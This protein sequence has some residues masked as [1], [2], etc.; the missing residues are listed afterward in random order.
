MLGGNFGIVNKIK[1]T[2]SFLLEE[3]A[4]E[5]F[6]PLIKLFL[7]LTKKDS[8]DNWEKKDSKD[9]WGET[10][11]EEVKQ[12]VDFIKNINDSVESNFDDE[13]VIKQFLLLT[14]GSIEEEPHLSSNQAPYWNSS[15]INS[16][17]EQ[18][19]GLLNV[20]CSFT[21]IL[22]DPILLNFLESELSFKE[23]KYDS[24]VLLES[25]ALVTNDL[26]GFHFSRWCCNK[27]IKEKIWEGNSK[28]RDILYGRGEARTSEDNWNKLVETFFQ[29]TNVDIKEFLKNLF[30]EENLPLLRKIGE[31]YDISE[32]E[33]LQGDEVKE[34]FDN[35]ELGLLDKFVDKIQHKL[36]E[37]YRCL[38]G[39][40]ELSNESRLEKLSNFLSVL[41]GDVDPV[42]EIDEIF[43]TSEK[44]T[45][46]EEE[47]FSLEG[48]SEKQIPIESIFSKI[49]KQDKININVNEGDKIM[50]ASYLLEEG[51][52]D[53]DRE[54]D[55]ANGFV[56]YN[57]FSIKLKS[58]VE[59]K[60]EGALL[61]KYRSKISEQ[62]ALEKKNR[63]DLEKDDYIKIFS[64]DFSS[65]YCDNEDEE[66]EWDREEKS[67]FI[68]KEE[69][70]IVNEKLWTRA[71]RVYEKN[72][73]LTNLITFIVEIIIKEKEIDRNFISL[74]TLSNKV[75]GFLRFHEKKA[76][77]LY[78]AFKNELEEYLSGVFSLI[79]NSYI[80]DG[81]LEEWLKNSYL[82]T[83]FAKKTF[84]KFLFG[85]SQLEISGALNE[86]H[87]WFVYQGINYNFQ[88]KDE[89]E[90]QDK[91][92]L[93]SD[94][95]S[96]LQKFTPEVAF[97]ILVNSQSQLSLNALEKCV[98]IL[99][100]D[101]IK[102]Q[103]EALIEKEREK[104]FRDRNIICSLTLSCD[105]S[106]DE[107]LCH[108]N[109]F[110]NFR[111]RYDKIAKY[112]PVKKIVRSIYARPIVVSQ[113]YNTVLNIFPRFTNF[114]KEKDSFF[115]FAMKFGF[116]FFPDGISRQF[117]KFFGVD[118]KD[119]SHVNEN[120]LNNFFEQEELVMALARCFDVTTYKAVGTYV[121]QI[122][123]IFKQIT[124][125][126]E[127]LNINCVFF[128][129]LLLNSNEKDISRVNVGITSLRTR[130]ELFSFKEWE[131]ELDKR[132]DLFQNYEDKKSDF[133]DY[134]DG[135]D[136]KKL[137]EVINDSGGLTFRER[138]CLT[139]SYFCNIKLTDL[140]KILYLK[141]NVTDVLFK[142]SQQLLSEFLKKEEEMLSADL[143]YPDRDIRSI[144]N[145]KIVELLGVDWRERAI[146]N[147]LALK[148]FLF[149][150]TF[151]YH[152][153]LTQQ[154]KVIPIPPIAKMYEGLSNPVSFELL[155]IVWNSEKNKWNEDEFSELNL[156]KFDTFNTDNIEK[157]KKDLEEPRVL[158]SLSYALGQTGDKIWGSLLGT[159]EL[160][161]GSYSC[162]SYKINE[163]VAESFSLD[164]FIVDLK[165]RDSNFLSNKIF[166]SSY[167][168]IH[169]SPW[170]LTD[171]NSSYFWTQNPNIPKISYF[172]N[173]FTFKESEIV[174]GKKGNYFGGCGEYLHFNDNNDCVF[175][176][177]EEK[178]IKKN[179]LSKKIIKPF[180]GSE[181]FED[182]QIYDYNTTSCEIES[183]LR[184]KK[185]K[186]YYYDE[187]YNV[188]LETP[189][190][191]KEEKIFEELKE[192]DK[193][194][195][196]EI[197]EY[198][199]D[200]LNWNKEETKEIKNK[201]ELLYI[202]YIEPVRQK[203]AKENFVGYIGDLFFSSGFK[204]EE[205]KDFL[206]LEE[207][208][209]EIE[210]ISLDET[211]IQTLE[212]ENVSIEE[213]IEDSLSSKEEEINIEESVED[214]LS[215]SKTLL[216][217]S[218]ETPI[219][220]LEEKST[221]RDP[222][223][224]TS[225]IPIPVRNFGGPSTSS[226]GIPVKNFPDPSMFTSR[227]RI[228]PPPPSTN[229][230]IPSLNEFRGG[231]EM[232]HSIPLTFPVGKETE[233]SITSSFS[234]IDKNDELSDYQQSLSSSQTPSETVSTNKE[235]HVFESNSAVPSIPF[236]SIDTNKLNQ[237]GAATFSSIDSSKISD[238][239]TFSPA[240]SFDSS[241]SSNNKGTSI[242]DTLTK[243]S[244]TE[245]LV[246]S[247][248]E[249]SKDDD[250][251]F[252]WKSLI[253]VVVIVLLVSI[254][255]V[256][257]SEFLLPKK[258]P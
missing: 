167:D 229:F 23:R 254:V 214:D 220:T 140:I 163:Q 69:V 233:Q 208:N 1:R 74:E 44:K 131:T 14:K 202:R 4:R 81:R 120:F 184:E 38:Y 93:Y 117:D 146:I 186:G 33:C 206:M 80:R 70:E 187:L 195:W 115:D 6:F 61:E 126:K 28:T 156:E 72:P 251:G 199:D 143:N 197:S 231:K 124:A 228:P 75:L 22:Y 55:Y 252:P 230:E 188:V 135:I 95:Y 34:F 198:I 2:F 86:F 41:P 20:F 48:E 134:L 236:S 118:L 191:L 21:N 256:G 165:K 225:G 219:Q 234:I 121:S 239:S 108:L 213:S 53:I 232:E 60:L 46:N 172:V 130:W 189:E 97:E 111:S 67:N 138:K 7:S 129:Q 37:K 36:T 10:S 162:F 211:P 255:V 8:R 66:F 173:P 160:T 246:T 122:D 77:I 18:V 227:S 105:I 91:V 19:D 145:K 207:K 212:E 147:Q 244:S 90:K 39:R 88:S 257:L 141:R 223:T 258:K 222:S 175:W 102:K 113:E 139:E 30:E 161:V 243:S 201:N 127:G 170:I 224:F 16:S 192:R 183:I 68:G 63:V 169:N 15:R 17:I 241:D 144:F 209:A 215:S 171:K 104:P 150:Y 11:D 71:A 125:N 13:S 110:E 27:E 85:S 133:I 76:Y 179:I 240:S 148:Y 168:N 96:F 65:V 45:V 107:S 116:N 237:S 154:E 194:K 82:K 128:Q 56:E 149:N 25:N 182:S 216:P 159:K 101:T 157:I 245:N 155:F 253:I 51:F 132:E 24:D 50:L 57:S 137:G 58:W 100:K 226:T 235:N 205:G 247:S 190:E 26:L 3:N 200:Y 32:L 12:L 158:L 185:K 136:Q 103:V 42:K 153:V 83:A 119:S 112:P 123:N 114:F 196:N 176:K 152:D 142:E 94:N 248:N 54:L 31:Q 87:Q 92:R 204:Y 193:D 84:S 174:K 178:Y 35:N 210:E 181:L 242:G 99:K 166:F 180:S 164:P 73:T 5:E 218:E 238:P 109:N 217:S 52:L 89:L 9:N 64:K 78:T 79:S 59:K 29:E 62:L 249:N 203:K 49:D 151:K 250:S 106:F 98:V 47:D 221:I 40:R 177:N 43:S